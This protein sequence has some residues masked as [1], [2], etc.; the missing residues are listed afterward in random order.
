LFY[1]HLKAAIGSI[2]AARRAGTQQDTAAA[3]VSNSTLPPHT[4]GSAALTW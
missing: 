3:T 1:S 4:S 2:R